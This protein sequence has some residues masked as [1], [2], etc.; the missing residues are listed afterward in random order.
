MSRLQS[1]GVDINNLQNLNE[2]Q[3][4]DLGITLRTQTVNV[5]T[6]TTRTITLR[7][8]QQLTIDVATLNRL[9]QQGVD[10]NNLQN[11][12]ESELEQ[13]GIVLTT[14]TVGIQDTGVR[15]IPGQTQTITLRNGQILTIDS[16]TLTRLQQQ[17][18]DI[19]NLQNLD[20]TQLEQL[21]IVITTRTVNVATPQVVR[22]SPVKILL[23]Y[24]CCNILLIYRCQLLL[25]L[26]EE[27]KSLLL[28]VL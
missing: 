5:G 23:L 28:L 27:L 18:V 12:S 11:L 16:A 17:G 1:Q 19:N 25:G 4:E 10:I 21:G 20:E 26:K 24:F 6:Q 15:I 2:R 9:Q 3:L 22:V 13:L 8:G 7:G 14:R